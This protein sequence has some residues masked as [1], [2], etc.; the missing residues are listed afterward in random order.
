ME[1][2]AAGRLNDMHKDAPPG[3]Y[4][5]GCGRIT[6][7]DDMHP[8]GPSPWDDPCCGICMDEMIA[9]MKTSTTPGPNAVGGEQGNAK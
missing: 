1:S 8:S 7:N 4:R 9:E 2:A 6:P 5:C 3:T